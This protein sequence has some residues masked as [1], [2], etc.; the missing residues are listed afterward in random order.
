MKNSKHHRRCACAHCVQ[1]RKLRRQLIAK[2]NNSHY[3]ASGNE[4][5]T[6]GKLIA[7]DPPEGGMAQYIADLD[8]KGSV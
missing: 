6:L 8:G 5:P 3:V 7:S 4:Q 2:R 1:L